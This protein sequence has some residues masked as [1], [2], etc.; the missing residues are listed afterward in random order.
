MSKP[1]IELI[2]CDSGDWDVLRVDLGEGFNYEGHSIPDYQ[3]IKLLNILGY[4]VEVRNI[5]DE[6]ME[7]GKY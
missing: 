1:F 4:E 3:W 2:T 7:N 6:D 5:S